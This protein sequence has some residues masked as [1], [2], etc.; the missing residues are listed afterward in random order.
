MA[1]FFVPFI[2]DEPAA[3]EVNGHKLLIVTSESEDMIADLDLLGGGEIREM[4]LAEDDSEG[5]KL[6]ADLAADI[7]GGVVLAP[8]GVR[9]R[10]MI[11][12]LAEE[13]PWIH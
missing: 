13:L 4:T 3:I 1:R 2:N 9:P 6:M 8:P 10:N 11:E 12:D 7:N 5:S